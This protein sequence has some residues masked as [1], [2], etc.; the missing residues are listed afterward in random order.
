M[1]PRRP[2]TKPPSPAAVASN[3]SPQKVEEARKLV[4]RKVAWLD[5]GTHLLELRDEMREIQKKLTTLETL[6][7]GI[8]SA[9]EGRSLLGHPSQPEVPGVQGHCLNSKEAAQF[10]GMSR[11][12]LNQ[13]RMRQEGPPAI[14]MGLRRVLY[15]VS[16]LAA[17]I[18]GRVEQR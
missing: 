2:S 12:S 3:L 15:R 10:L 16:D 4:E 1:R 14:K 5:K 8:F 18:E 17:W 7:I 11:S 13:M 6:V 9:V